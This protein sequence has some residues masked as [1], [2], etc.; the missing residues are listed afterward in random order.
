MSHF[1]LFGTQ[2]MFVL[3]RDAAAFLEQGTP[4]AGCFPFRNEPHI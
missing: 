2:K 4:A 1:E 3:N